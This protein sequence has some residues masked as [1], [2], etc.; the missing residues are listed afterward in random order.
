MECFWDNS[1]CSVGRIFFLFERSKS[2]SDSWIFIASAV[3]RNPIPVYY[4][5]QKIRLS[6][7]SL[8]MPC[9]V[10]NTIFK[11][12]LHSLITTPPR[13]SRMASRMVDEMEVYKSHLNLYIPP[14]E[15]CV[16]A[17]ILGN[18][19]VSPHRIRVYERS[20]PDALNEMMS[21]LQNGSGGL[22]GITESC[23]TIAKD[24]GKNRAVY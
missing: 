14:T 20:K 16:L 12:R 17:E 13:P 3:L 15:R 11:A 7:I 8:Y 9:L 2:S 5:E 10:T 18:G 1:I 21:A 23:E 6:V 4:R 22:L 24:L 19:L